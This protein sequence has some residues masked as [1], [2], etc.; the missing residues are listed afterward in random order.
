[1]RQQGNMFQMKEQVKTTEDEWSKVEAGNLLDK[2]FK[3]MFVKMFKQLRRKL[4]VENEKLEVF[5]KELE[6]IKNQTE[7]QNTITEIKNTLE[8]I[9]NRSDNTEE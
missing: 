2:E 6:S 7:M 4:D 3:V 5:N 8:E 1:M 9:N